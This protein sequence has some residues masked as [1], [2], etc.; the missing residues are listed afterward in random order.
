MALLVAAALLTVSAH[1]L[2]PTSTF[3]LTLAGLLNIMATYGLYGTL[4]RVSAGRRLHGTAYAARSSQIWQ[5]FRATKLAREM[6]VYASRVLGGGLILAVITILSRRVSLPLLAAAAF[7]SIQW[8][9]FRVTAASLPPAL[10][11]LG[12]SAPAVGKALHDFRRALS[13]LR[14]V[15]LLDVDPAD[16]AH[17]P[18]RL[19]N[20]R[21]SDDGDWKAVFEVLRSAARVVLLDARVDTP[22]LRYEAHAIVASSRGQ[23]IVVVEQD[24][25][26][27]LIEH[28]DPAARTFFDQNATFVEPDS[29]YEASKTALADQ[30]DLTGWS[31]S[32]P[33]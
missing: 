17:D 29:A 9:L 5:V 22:A 31:R 23:S 28:L 30:R 26:A 6:Q 10:I 7:Y 3:E 33:L 18:D 2:L 24:G 13:P 20:F 1:R 21:T 14:V 25:R 15:S 8:L 27:A 12:S 16:P 4:A 32:N 19:D 11:M